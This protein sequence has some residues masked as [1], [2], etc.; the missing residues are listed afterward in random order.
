MRRFREANQKIEAEVQ[1]SI[2]ITPQAVERVGDK[3]TQ[4]VKSQQSIQHGLALCDNRGTGKPITFGDQQEKLKA[5]SRKF[6]NFVV[7]VYGEPFSELFCC[8]PRNRTIR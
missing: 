8:G 1:R 7:G 5:R 2:G 3:I 4:G 6:I